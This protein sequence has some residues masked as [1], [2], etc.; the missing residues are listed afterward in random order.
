MNKKIAVIDY[1]AGNTMSVIKA[2]EYLGTDVVLTRDSK[3]LVSADKIIFPGVG[4]YFDAMKKLESYQLQETISE[5]I[6]GG[7]PF[8]G[9]CLGMQ[10]LFNSS[11]ETIGSDSSESCIEGLHILDGN[12]VKFPD[13]LTEPSGEILKI[14][15]MGWNSLHITNPQS[16]LLQGIPEGSF[17]YFVHSYYLHAAD[18]ADVCATCYYGIDFDCAVEKG[19]IFG[20]QFH[21]EKSGDTGLQILKNFC[22]L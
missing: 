18:T 6:N 4:A 13:S 20:C 10:L 1:D 12:I 3:T 14:P 17:A 21:P 7:Q 22:E 19:N 5:L 9:I 8:L 2:L 11:E 15:H 16:K